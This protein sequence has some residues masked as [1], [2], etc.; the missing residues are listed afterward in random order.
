M[1]LAGE[2]KNNADPLMHKTRLDKNGKTIEKKRDALGNSANEKILDPNYC[3]SCY[4]AR[5]GCCNTCD[6]V[7]LAYLGLGWDW[8]GFEKFEQ[9]F[10]F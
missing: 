1:D 6:D 5:D 9:V 7:R 3:G 4:G 2:T 10:R 8:K